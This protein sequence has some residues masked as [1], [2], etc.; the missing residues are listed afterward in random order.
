MNCQF[1]NKLLTFS[2]WENDKEII[3]YDCKHCPVLVSFYFLYDESSK[4][5]DSYVLTKIVFMID[6]KGK[7]YLWTNNF[8]KNNSYIIN[9]YSM[10]IDPLVVKFPKIMNITP[11]NVVERLA[12]YMLWI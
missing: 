5:H 8:I 3:I 12:F 1:C 9:L 2:R 10:N 4:A 7:L 11:D 6:I